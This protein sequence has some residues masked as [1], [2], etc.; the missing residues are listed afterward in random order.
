[1]SKSDQ[2]FDKVTGEVFAQ[3]K[4]SFGELNTRDLAIIA[5]VD[6]HLIPIFLWALVDDSEVPEPFIDRL[7]EKENIL[8]DFTEKYGQE[9]Q[10]GMVDVFLKYLSTLE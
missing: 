2:L 8:K 5:G 9:L 6:K 7:L 10:D 1:M 3:L 4:N